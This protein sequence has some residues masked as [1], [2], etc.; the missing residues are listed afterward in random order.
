M[1]IEA[2]VRGDPAELEY[3]PPASPPPKEF[4]MTPRLGALTVTPNET[5]VLVQCTCEGLEAA[6]QDAAVP[7]AGPAVGALKKRPKNRPPRNGAGP[8]PQPPPPPP[9]AGTR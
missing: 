3:Q 1:R 4:K 5:Y 7:T 6:S 8:P 9:G 2:V